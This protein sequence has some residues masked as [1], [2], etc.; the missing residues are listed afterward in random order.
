MIRTELR[1]VGAGKS[2]LEVATVGIIPFYD[3]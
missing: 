3:E 2:V 1:P